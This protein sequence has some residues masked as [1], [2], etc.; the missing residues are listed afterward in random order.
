MELGAG[1]LAGR[2]GGLGAGIAAAGA[3][4]LLGAWPFSGHAELGRRRERGRAGVR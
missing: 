3:A 4:L 2:A 1:V